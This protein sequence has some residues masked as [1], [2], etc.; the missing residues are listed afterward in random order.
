MVVVTAVV[1]IL[2]SA[3]NAAGAPS[4]ANSTCTITVAQ[5]PARPGCLA[6]PVPIVRLCPTVG[7]VPPFDDV[8]FDL[9]VMDDAAVPAPIVGAMVTVYE[10][11]GSV[12]LVAPAPVATV[13]GGVASITV[14][15]GGG[16]GRIN[17]CV[18][19]VTF[20]GV[21]VRSP[22]VAGGALCATCPLPTA[23]ASFVAAND[24]NNP[25]CGFFSK[26]GVVVP[27][28]NDAWD[29]NCDNFVN[30]SDIL[31]NLGKGGLLQHFGHGGPLGPKSTCP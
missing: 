7:G 27:G 16:S 29:L 12:N 4:P 14:K 1:G 9:I 25:C 8:K 6:G 18:D 10:T 30:A 17:V 2:A 24:V 26:F 20:C 28:V 19:G 22:D 11:S 23:G 5:N 3:E 15:A 21:I 13:A 31:G